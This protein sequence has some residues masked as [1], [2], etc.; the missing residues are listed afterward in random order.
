V[1]LAVGGCAP[2]GPAV[3][4]ELV[5]TVDVPGTL[6]GRLGVEA[7]L[8]VDAGDLAESAASE[9][10]AVASMPWAVEQ[11][12]VYANYYKQRVIRTR[13]WA[14]VETPYRDLHAWYRRSSDP[15][16]REPVRGPGGEE[17]RRIVGALHAWIEEGRDRPAP[18]TVDP[19]L[20]DRLE[21]LGYIDLGGRAR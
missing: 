21:A 3:S 11:E 4:D 13:E 17:E 5:S 10:F 20:M 1:P 2:F 15:D 8:P 7:V 12:G 16:E 9:A 19:E 6:L 18:T 14:Y